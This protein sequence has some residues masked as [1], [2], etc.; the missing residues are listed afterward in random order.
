MKRT[1]FAAGT[2]L[3]TGAIGPGGHFAPGAIAEKFWEL[4]EKRGT[5]EIIY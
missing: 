5:H 2:V 3:V 1:I 4:Y